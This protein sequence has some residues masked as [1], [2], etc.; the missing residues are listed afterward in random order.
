MVNYHL[1]GRFQPTGSQLRA[2][3]AAAGLSAPELAAAT[4]LGVN[5][6]RRAEAVDGA[7]PLTKAG[8][9]FIRVPA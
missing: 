8:I 9:R 4:G 6:I 7:V 1:Y 5:T 3:R 2:A